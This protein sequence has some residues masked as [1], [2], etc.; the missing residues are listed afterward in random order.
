MRMRTQEFNNIKSHSLLRRA[1]A[2]QAAVLLSFLS[3]AQ[4]AFA[5]EAAPMPVT[6]INANTFYK[7]AKNSVIDTEK[8]KQYEASAA[9]VWDFQ[10]RLSAMSDKALEGD[11]AAGECAVQWLRQWAEGRAMQGELNEQARYERQWLTGAWAFSYHKVRRY[12]DKA[13]RA[14]IDPWL[15][16]LATATLDRFK[17]IRA[18]RNN[19]LYWSAL[20]GA[21][22]VLAIEDDSLW[23]RVTALYDEAL[24]HI[25][26]QGEL[27]KELGRG[28]R[29]L[30][31]HN[32]SAAPLVMIAEIARQRGSDF[33]S[34]QNGALHR[35]VKLV[36]EGSVQPDIFAHNFQLEPQVRTPRGHVVGWMILYNNHNPIA[37]LAHFI[38]PQQRPIYPRLGGDMLSLAKEWK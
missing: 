30:L 36:L 31:Y 23:P 18:T 35:L 4:A 28:G 12:T 8:M 37:S 7:D 11:A 26:P 2:M 13:N 29:A 27:P 34:R 6:S 3:L 16:A 19:H 1:F 38:N 25:G 14:V 20:A 5:C 10:D 17:D 24:S 15:K 21:A 33:Y 9:P 22:V 32:W